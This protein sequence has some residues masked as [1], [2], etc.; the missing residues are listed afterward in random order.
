[1]SARIYRPARN[2]MQSGTA[3]TRDWVLEHVSDTA[4]DIDPLMG[5]TSNEDTQA[6]VRLRF[7]TKEAALAY[8]KDKGIDA[9][10]VE[11]HSRKANVRPGGYGDN[12]A[13]NRRQVWTH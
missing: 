10:V 4:R 5:W 12:F 13:T 1:M 6:Q 7:P 3:K 11:P 8:A 2:A 9:V